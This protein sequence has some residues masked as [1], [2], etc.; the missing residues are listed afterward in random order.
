MAIIAFLVSWLAIGGVR[1]QFQKGNLD[2]PRAARN[3]IPLPQGAAA[4]GLVIMLACVVVY[5]GV[6]DGAIYLFSPQ[7]FSNWVYILFKTLYTGGAA[8]LAAALAI[9]SVFREQSS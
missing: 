7:G 1:G 4:R 8:A 3:K 9:W 5:G 6:L 2:Q